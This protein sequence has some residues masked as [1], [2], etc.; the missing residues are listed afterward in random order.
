MHSTMY[1]ICMYYAYSF[2]F[3]FYRW[4][5]RNRLSYLRTKSSYDSQRET[6]EHPLIYDDANIHFY[7]THGSSNTYLIDGGRSR[8]IVRDLSGLSQQVIVMDN[9][10]L[11]PACTHGYPRVLSKRTSNTRTQSKYYPKPEFWEPQFAVKKKAFLLILENI[12]LTLY[13]QLSKNE[14]KLVWLIFDLSVD[15]VFFAH[16]FQV[17]KDH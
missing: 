9:E 14:E 11:R 12:W 3:I 17:T 13:F 16:R 4:R 15:L 7:R 8:P 10:Y 5:G 6:S 2:L 1:T